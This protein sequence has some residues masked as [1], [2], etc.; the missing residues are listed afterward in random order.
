[1]QLVFVEDLMEALEE[2]KAVR[3]LFFSFGYWL[4]E[5]TSVSYRLMSYMIHDGEPVMVK[6]CLLISVTKIHSSGWTIQY[7]CHA[8]GEMLFVFSTN[9]PCHRK[10][11]CFEHRHGPQNN[12][13]CIKIYVENNLIVILGAFPRQ[14]M[15][16][17]SIWQIEIYIDILCGKWA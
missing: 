5:C 7:Y 9:I 16:T 11:Y 12:F 4:I 10:E 1:M 6:T 8:W 14:F 3:T 13:D 15:H 2:A 17:I